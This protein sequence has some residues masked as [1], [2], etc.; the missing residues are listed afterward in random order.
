MDSRPVAELTV[1]TEQRD[2]IA[3][4]SLREVRHPRPP[5]AA[6]RFTVSYGLREYLSIVADFIPIALRERG[7]PCERIGFGTRLMLAVLVP[8]VF[9]FKKLAIGDCRFSV[10]EHGLTR[11]SRRQP[12]ALPWGDVLAVYPLSRGYLVRKASGAMPLPYRCFSDEE[13]QRF[14]R[15]AASIVPRP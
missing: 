12:L 9:L 4:T 3:S 13:R 7:K 10:D 1:R 5:D 15:W 8:P 14:E 11:H 2:S 6:I